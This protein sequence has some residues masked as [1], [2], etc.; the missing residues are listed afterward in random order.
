M[1]LVITAFLFHITSTLCAQTRFPEADEQSTIDVPD[2]YAMLPLEDIP[3]TFEAGMVLTRSNETRYGYQFGRPLDAM[4]RILKSPARIVLKPLFGKL[5]KNPAP[6]DHWGLLFSSEPPFNGTNIIKQV[7]RMVPRPENGTVFELRNSIN[8][9]LV[10]LDVKRWEN[11]TPHRPERVKFL[12]TLNRTD[13][14]LVNIGRAY[15][16][17]VGREGF[18]NFY[19]NCQI[20]TH[21]YAQAL[22]PQPQLPTR[23]DQLFGKFVWWFKDWMKTARWAWKKVVNFLGFSNNEPEVDSSAAFVPVEQLLQYHATDESGHRNAPE[24]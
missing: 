18:H 12:G 2:L 6:F 19:R 10:Y 16:Q 15:I 14:E 9:G 8:T 13:I 11:Y 4:L 1:R 23:M 21:W 20:F 24:I 22:W 3:T 7:G 5:V 17:H